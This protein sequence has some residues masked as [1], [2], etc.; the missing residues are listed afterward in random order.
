LPAPGTGVL[1]VANSPWLPVCWQK[2]PHELRREKE[3]EE[4]EEEGE[5]AE[6][7]GGGYCNLPSPIARNP[8]FSICLALMLRPTLVDWRHWCRV[9]K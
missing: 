9:P 6:K 2:A 3:E 7:A 5:E 1:L 8:P 4:E